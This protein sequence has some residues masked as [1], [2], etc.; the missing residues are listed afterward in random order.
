MRNLIKAISI[1]GMLALAALTP[2]APAFA[3]VSFD[4]HIGPPAPRA[5]VIVPAPY[6]GAV[7]IA[8]YHRWDYATGAYIWV[9]GRW[10]RP[11]HPGWVWHGARYPRRGGRYGFVDGHWGAPGRGRGGA[12]PG[13]RR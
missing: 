11:P 1:C 2:A 8:G 4:I 5:E 13:G 7:W 6:P 3:Q 10:D 9:P 12:V